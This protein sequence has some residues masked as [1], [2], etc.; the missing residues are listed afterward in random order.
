MLVRSLFK[1][2]IHAVKRE[3]VIVLKFDDVNELALAANTEAQN[4]SLD[5]KDSNNMRKKE[6]S[7]VSKEKVN[8][9]KVKKFEKKA[10]ICMFLPG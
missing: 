8:Q 5:E 2:A 10:Q 9:T 4:R 3:I 1:S 6:H 7:P